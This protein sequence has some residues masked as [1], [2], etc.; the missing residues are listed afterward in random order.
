MPVPSFVLSETNGGGAVATDSIAQIVFAAVDLNSNTTNLAVL[1]PLVVPFSGVVPVYSFEKMLRLKVTQ[2]ASNSLSAF[3][4][5]FSPFPPQDAGLATAN[6]AAYYGVP[7][8]YTAPVSTASVIA[9]TLSSTNISQ[10]GAAITA[11]ANAIGAYSG[12]WTQQIKASVGALGGNML[13]GN[14]WGLVSLLY[15]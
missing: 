9:T 13:W 14:P 3:G 6:V 12:Y 10:P 1:Y 7:S 4:I 8:G 15:N 2:V 11:P 5:Y